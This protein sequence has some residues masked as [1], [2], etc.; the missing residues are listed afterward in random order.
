M[1]LVCSFVQSPVS[2]NLRNS[3]VT[4]FSPPPIGHTGELDGTEFSHSALA[5]R[6][7]FAALVKLFENQLKSLSASD[8]DVRSHI[9]K[10]KEAA[11]HG[12]DLSQQLI[13]RSE[14]SS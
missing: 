3:V 5:I 7:D 10:A 8:E 1:G 14:A 6:Q 12:L 9:R 13:E 2:N 4:N 11:Q